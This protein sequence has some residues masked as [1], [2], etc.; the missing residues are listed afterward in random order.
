MLQHVPE[1][2][3]LRPKNALLHIYAPSCLSF[4]LDGLLGC[5]H[6][7]ALVNNAAI[8]M[9]IQVPES[10][11]S[12]LLSKPRSGAAGYVNILRKIILRSKNIV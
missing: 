2:S 8:N 12:I 4:H 11:F 6:L 1:F 9:S 3:F 5:F 7:L 10:S